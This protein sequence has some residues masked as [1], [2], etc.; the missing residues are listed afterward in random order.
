MSARIGLLSLLRAALVVLAAA[1]SAVVLPRIGL[2]G[3]DL[4]L[5]VVVAGG[6]LGG[7]ARGALLGLGAGWVVDLMPPAAAT[8]G[9]AALTYAVAGAVAGLWHR[10][11]ARSALLP[12]LATFAAAGVVVGAGIAGAVESGWPVDWAGAGWS[13]ALTTVV[14]L[15][16]VPALVRAERGLVRRRLA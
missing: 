5:L 1:F 12:P 14:G 16:A 8:L 6:I 13:V 10:D 3:P 2:P 15:V 11:G 4:V 9:L 7:P